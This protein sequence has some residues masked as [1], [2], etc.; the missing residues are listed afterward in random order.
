VL[1]TVEEEEYSDN[2]SSNSDSNTST[3]ALENQMT[4]YK[5][6]GW[7][8]QTGNFKIVPQHDNPDNHYSASDLLTPAE[9]LSQKNRRTASRRFKG[10]ESP[11]NFEQ[12]RDSQF[13]K[14]SLNQ[15]L[16]DSF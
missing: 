14:S 8:M 15:D 9:R 4:R 3:V 12:S 1:G 10:N 6:P 16:D 13:S 11:A 5:A 2:D 7:G